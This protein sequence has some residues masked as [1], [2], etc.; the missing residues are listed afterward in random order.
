ML[1]LLLAIIIF[2]LI[3]NVSFS[4]EIENKIEVE[5]FLGS[6]RY[7]NAVENNPGLIK[8]LDLKVER[9]YAIEPLNSDKIDDFTEISTVVYNKAV[10][11]EIISVETFLQHS[12][13]E[14]FNILFYNFPM[15]EN[16]GNGHFLLKDTDTVISVYSA[17]YLNKLL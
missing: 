12:Q 15:P 10:K 2:S 13:E 5:Q 6:Q 8:F 9:G 7:Q 11:G 17:Q 14:D 4:Q 3:S 16:G 1:K